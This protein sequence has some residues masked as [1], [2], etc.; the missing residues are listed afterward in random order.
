MKTLILGTGIIGTIYG[1]ALAETGL[2]VTHYVRKGKSAAYQDGVT[3]DLLD[4]RKG[5]QK[6]NITRYALKCV[7]DISS[8]DDYNLIILP[9]NSYQ[10]G[11]FK[12][13]WKTRHS[14]VK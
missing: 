7:E 8:S 2:D 5:H 11:V 3:L 6:K 12:M 10:M 1:W 14:L 4:E 13:S 9:T